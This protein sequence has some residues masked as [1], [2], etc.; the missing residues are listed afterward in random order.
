MS[1]PAWSSRRP[2]RQGQGDQQ[3]LQGRRDGLRR[4]DALVAAAA[5]P[6]PTAG[7]TTAS[8]STRS[9]STS[10]ARS[11]S[12][13]CCRT[14]ACGAWSRCAASIR[15]SATSSWPARWWSPAR[16]ATTPSSSAGGGHRPGDN[17]GH[18]RHRP[19]RP[20]RLPRAQD[21]GRRDRHRVRAAARA[22][23]AGAEDGRRLR[24]RS[25]EGRLHRGS[26][27][28]HRGMGASLYLEA[29]GLPTAV[30]PGI[31]QC[32]WEGPH[33]QRDRRG[34]GA[35][36]GQDARH[37]RSAAGAPRAHRGFAGATAATARSRA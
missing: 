35:R 22:R 26:A 25:D 3:A 15:T 27:A 2:G 24:H 31:E 19:G 17:V 7:R 5:S 12:T 20:R 37:R 11:A 9:A 8:G 1:S 30:Y 34:R 4:G 33:A 32:I 14:A 10:T 28:P 36:R 23:R 29:T 6:A 21:D 13:S 16:S 18:L